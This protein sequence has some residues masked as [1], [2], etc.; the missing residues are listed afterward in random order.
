[1][2]LTHPLGHATIDARHDRGAAIIVFS[3]VFFSQ[4]LSLKLYNLSTAPKNLAP[5]KMKVLPDE[6]MPWLKQL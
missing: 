3:D 1:M 5:R 4:V 6:E 2:R